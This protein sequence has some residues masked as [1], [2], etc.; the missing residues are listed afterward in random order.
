MESPE[1]TGRTSSSTSLLG[2]SSKK[3]LEHTDARWRKSN[4]PIRVLSSYQ[5]VRFLAVSST[6]TS[7]HEKEEAAAEQNDKQ[8]ANGVVPP[9]EAHVA[10]VLTIL[11]AAAS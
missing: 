5:Q 11:G 6:A 4:E 1:E 9:L 8:E 2:C 10:P 7:E 3:G